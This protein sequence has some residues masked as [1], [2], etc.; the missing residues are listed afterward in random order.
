MLHVA[1][2]VRNAIAD[3]IRRSLASPITTDVTCNVKCGATS[4]AVRIPPLCIGVTLLALL[5][6]IAFVLP[7]N[8]IST[9]FYPKESRKNKFTVVA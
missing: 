2:T 3:K 1:P 7:S 8:G 6:A 4:P 5:C 9:N